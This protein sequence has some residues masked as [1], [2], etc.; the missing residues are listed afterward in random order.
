MKTLTFL[1]L[2]CCM[3]PLAVYGQSAEALLQKVPEAV[4]SGQTGYAE[5]LFRQACQANASQAEMFY[6]TRVDKSSDLALPFAASLA[7]RYREAANYDKAYLF[8]KEQLAHKPDDVNLLVA[9]GEMEVRRGK[10]SDALETYEKVITLDADN[11]QACIFLGNYYYLQAEDARKK[12]D[13]DYRRIP[14]P[15]RMQYARYRDELSE[16]FDTGYTKA[17]TYLRHVMTR[18]PSMGAGQ[19]LEKID[20]LE[21]EIN[22]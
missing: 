15:T 8:Y 5:S 9:S 2:Y 21:R 6:W 16:L 14:S 11:L 17:R 4:A 1:L 10:L 12:L 3:L 7:E 13:A 18:F 20:S 22:P 19:T